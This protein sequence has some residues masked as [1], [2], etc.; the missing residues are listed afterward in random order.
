[1]KPYKYYAAIGTLLLYVLNAGCSKTAAPPREIETE[2]E[3]IPSDPRLKCSW[4]A[5]STVDSILTDYTSE[6]V[7]FDSL[8]IL[9]ATEIRQANTGYFGACNLPKDVRKNGLAVKISGYVITY[10]GIQDQNFAANPF[11]LTTIEVIKK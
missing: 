6:V 5:N 9:R 3:I 2:P 7:Q 11:E 8:F 10:P 4:P 1:M